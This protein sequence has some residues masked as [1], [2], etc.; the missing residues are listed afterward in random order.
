MSINYYNDNAKKFIENT[1]F[2]SMGDLIDDFI[3]LLPKNATVLDLGCGSGRDSLYFKKNGFDVYAMDGSKEMIEHTKKYIGDR[4][5]LATFD[6]YT[7]NI[8]FDGIW[9]LASLLHVPRND[10]EMI[11]NKYINFLK[12]DGFLFMSFKNREID[13]DKDGRNFTCFTENTLLELIKPIDKIELVKI[14]HTTDVRKDRPDERW[15]SVIIRR[16]G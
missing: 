8:K 7:T 14:I 11:L 9:A 4:A 6:D 12:E 13:Y 10:I 3:A 2:V 1:F 16:K 5:K 15:I